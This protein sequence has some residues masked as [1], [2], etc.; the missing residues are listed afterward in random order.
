MDQIWLPF[1]RQ[2]VVSTIID[3]DSR[4]VSDEQGRVQA[5]SSHWQADFSSQAEVPALGDALADQYVKEWPADVLPASPLG[6]IALL[7]ALSRAKHTAPGPDGIPYGG[8]ADTE[9]G[10]TLA[11]LGGHLLSHPCPP[12]LSFPIISR[13]TKLI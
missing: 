13:I 5:L 8:W 7:A 2:L 12:E 11:L 1:E 3:K 10:T 9:T 4:H 6:R